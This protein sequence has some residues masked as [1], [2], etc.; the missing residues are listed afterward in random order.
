MKNT[1]AMWR[2]FEISSGGG[3]SYV[4]SS[5]KMTEAEAKEFWDSGDVEIRHDAIKDFFMCKHSVCAVWS[6]QKKSKA[7]KILESLEAGRD[8]WAEFHLGERHRE[9][10]A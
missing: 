2:V 3:M 8:A 1:D 10:E 7:Q 9:G 5:R 4:M 6:T